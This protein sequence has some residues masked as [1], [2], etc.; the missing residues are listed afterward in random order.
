[1]RIPKKTAKRLYQSAIRNPPRRNRV[2]IIPG[3]T[4][5]GRYLVVR[6]LARGG[7]GTVY[8]A[9]DE[10]LDA[11]VALK[12]TSLDSEEFRRQF[13]REARLLARLSHPALPRVSDHFDE[14]GGQFLVMQFVGGPDLEEMRRAREG[15]AF[16]VA[17]VLEWADQLLDALDYLHSQEPPVIHR[18]IKPQNLK[19]GARGQIIL[20][21]FGLAKGYTTQTTP[22]AASVVGY[23]PAYAPLEQ[24]QGAGT[25]ARSDLYSLAATLYHLMTG[26]VPPNALARADAVLNAEPDPLR[27]ADELSANVSADV[28]AV[29]RQAMA[30]RRDHRIGSAA[31]MRRA[32]READKTPRPQVSSRQGMATVFMPPASTDPQP[33]AAQTQDAT[34]ATQVRAAS[35]EAATLHA[36]QRT[37]AGSQASVPTV[38]QPIRAPQTPA[39][40]REKKSRSVPL[41][42][43]GLAALLLLAVFGAVL[44]FT[45]FRKSDTGGVP[46]ANPNGARTS[47]GQAA[48][49]S[50]A[51]T[52]DTST[53]ANNASATSTADAGAGLTLAGHEKDVHALAFSPDGRL[54]ATGSEDQTVKLWDAHTG[55]LRET[56]PALGSDARPVAFSSDGRT[57][58][59]LLYYIPAS[60]NCAVALYDTQG[61]RLGSEKRRIQMPTCPV[62]AAALSADGRTL[63]AGASELGLWDTETGEL[64]HKLEGN[65][66]VVDSIAFSPD[67][68]WLA[69]AGHVDGMVRLWNLR[70]GKYTEQEIRAHAAPAAVAFSPDSKTLATGGYDGTLKLWDASGGAP[71]RTF[72]Y[73]SSFIDSIAFSPDGSLVACGGAGPDGE[74]KVWDA[75][76]GDL[77]FDLKAGGL[78][79]SLGFSPDGRALASASDKVVKVW[80][81]SRP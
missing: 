54:L 1:L 44:M 52:S 75:R 38:P 15:G 60:N 48:Q 77:K 64:K 80:N 6:Q 7:M 34:P 57:L 36:G 35:S 42:V 19:L 25:D 41:F 17:Q 24:I 61:G 76:T 2:M 32:L 8:E 59:V 27:P 69:S 13:E 68:S 28:A 56:S 81:L 33:R 50:N 78:V 49:P 26:A 45:V 46:V 66:T 51:T 53:T 3:T 30:L 20:L 9:V 31:A 16:P 11:T 73:A 5:Q 23:T 47:K 62:A 14:G 12:E 29:L 39:P 71:K 43:G 37:A 74:V 79:N 65:A 18:D 21:D 72:D 67:G 22:L 40:A 55:Q 10:R 70:D 4:L 58:A 63:A